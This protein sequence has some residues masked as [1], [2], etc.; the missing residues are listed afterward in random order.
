VEDDSSSLMKAEIDC[1]SGQPLFRQEGELDKVNKEAVSPSSKSKRMDVFRFLVMA[2]IF[3]VVDVLALFV[4]SPFQAAGVVAFENPADPL[5]LVYLFLSLIVFTA[6]MLLIARFWKKRFVQ[7]IVLGSTGLLVF[8]VV[9]PFLAYVVPELWSLGLSLGLVAVLLVLL[10]KYPEW[11]VIDVCGILMGLAAM[12]MLGISL[13]VPL[14]VAL[15]I[16]LAVYDAISVYQTKHMADLADTVLDLKLPV[17]LVIPWSLRY[18]LIKETRSLKERLKEREREKEQGEPEESEASLIGLGDIVMP[19]TLA[20]SA[21][22]NVPAGYGLLIALAVMLGTVVGYA[23]LAFASGGR[24]Q[25]GL[26]YLCSG[27]LLGY[28]ISSYLLTGGL[29]GIS[30]LG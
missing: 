1:V 18:S 21:F 9:F 27:A 23:V 3:V 25:A 17:V 28:A 4:A 15:L 13:R 29:A 11:Y 5:N 22:A 6:F 20:V 30:L 12:T 24:P 2:S 16:L 26:P 7:I 8:Y 14:V 19:G 10:V